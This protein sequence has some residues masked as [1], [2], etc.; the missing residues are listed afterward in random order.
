MYKKQ[1]I[2]VTAA[3]AVTCFLYFQQPV[4]AK[5]SSA[6]EGHTNSTEAPA[7]KVTDV[8]VEMASAAAKLAIGPALAEQISKTES[9]LGSTADEA[10]KLDL[11]KKLAGQWDQLNQ[12]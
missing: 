8:S 6:S 12:A 9:Q 11:Q 4:A 7:K 3:I 5:K 2:V 10:A 1:I